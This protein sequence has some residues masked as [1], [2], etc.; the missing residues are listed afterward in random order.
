[1][2]PRRAP[3][4]TAL[5]RVARGRRPGAR[6]LGDRQPGRTRTAGCATSA[7]GTPTRRA[8]G[9]GRAYAQLRLGALS[10][11]APFPRRCAPERPV[12]DRRRARPGRPPCR[13]GR[14][15][16][17]VR[18]AGPRDV[19]RPAA[20]GPGPHRRRADAS[21][22]VPTGRP[23]TPRTSPPLREVADRAA[24]ALDNSRLY[25][26]QRR[27]AETLQR[28]M[29][30]APPEPD[31]AEIVVRYQPAVAGRRGRRRL[32]RRVPPAR[33]RDGAGHR[34]R[35]GP[36]H[37]GR[38]RHGPAARPAARHRLPARDR[39]GRGAA[40]ARRRHRRAW[41]WARWPPPPIARIEQ[42][43]EERAARRH[44]GALV[45]RRS[46]AAA[47]AARRRPYRGAHRRRAPT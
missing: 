40:R 27:L 41:R 35:R 9:D 37:R 25:E 22:A 28:S 1:M 13:P 34:R 20:A 42:T 47:A 12:V 4:R 46:P 33:R 45:Q 30:T 26:Q 10:S 14:S 5:Q 36:R 23:P 32:V 2:G 11:T 19:G 44:P 39:A 6:R 16:D 38:G 43:D 29:L 15:R 17:A 21:T 3:R 18:A 24:L 7:A 8:R 31:H